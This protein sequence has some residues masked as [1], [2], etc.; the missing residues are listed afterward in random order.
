[1]T[2]DVEVFVIRLAMIGVLL[3]FVVLVARWL[4]EGMSSVAERPAAVLPGTAIMVVVAPGQSGLSAGE[5]LPVPAR[6]SVGRGEENGLVVADP[7]VSWRHA[8]LEK[9]DGSWYVRDLASTNGTFLDGRP[10]GRRPERL[11]HGSRLRFGTVVFEFR[12]RGSPNV[13]ALVHPQQ[14]AQQGEVHYQA[15][16]A[17]THE[18]QSHASRRY[19]A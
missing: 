7:S 3:A 5:E 14:Q 18:R 17:V 16:T 10:V 6:L 13:P 1:M 12:L 2:P 9:R 8:L 4:R 11:R 19:E 15:R